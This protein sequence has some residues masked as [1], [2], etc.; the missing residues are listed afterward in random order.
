LLHV[1][2][3]HCALVVQLLVEPV[4][5]L[6][7]LQI[8][9]APQV[10]HGPPLLPHADAAVPFWQTPLSQQPAPHDGALAQHG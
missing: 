6:T 8:W 5:H 4:Q 2:L 10:W 3:Q 9:L 7:S 1:P